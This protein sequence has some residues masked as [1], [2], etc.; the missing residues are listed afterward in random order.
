[1]TTETIRTAPASAQQ[2][3]DVTQFLALEAQLLD[4]G[5]EEEWFDLLDDG[6]LYEIP[7]RQA[8]E[9]RSNEVSAAVWR[10]HDTKAQI[11][12]R[13]NRLNTGHAYSEAP[14]PGRCAWSAA[15]GPSRAA[16]PTY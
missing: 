1:M 7:V 4:E 16:A 8:T 6:L 11:R 2:L 14:R 12:V 5:R 9:P 13:I 15:S 3:A 10:V